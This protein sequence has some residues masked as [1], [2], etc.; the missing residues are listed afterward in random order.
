M[1][2]DVDRAGD[3]VFDVPGKGEGEENGAKNWKKPHVC[4]VIPACSNE[5]NGYDA[6]GHAEDSGP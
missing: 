6:Y 5:R 3:S 1:D 2:C 4:E